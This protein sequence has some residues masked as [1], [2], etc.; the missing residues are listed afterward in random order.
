[1]VLGGVLVT[2]LLGAEQIELCNH[3]LWPTVQ[4]AE[5][6]AGE[7]LQLQAMRLLS[8]GGLL[9]RV[10]IRMDCMDSSSLRRVRLLDITRYSAYASP[11]HALSC[12]L[13]ATYVK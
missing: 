10:S 2:G 5:A 6:V 13:S 12:L 9:L 8:S 3:S 1:M 11:A 4:G 7:A